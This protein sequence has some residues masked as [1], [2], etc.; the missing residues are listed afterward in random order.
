MSCS[1]SNSAVRVTRRI[2][3]TIAQ[4]VKV[5]RWLGESKQLANLASMKCNILSL[6]AEPHPLVI[7]VDPY[8]RIEHSDPLFN[9]SAAGSQKSK[10][11]RQIWEMHLRVCTGG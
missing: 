5:S 2:R 10:K 3:G 6:K 4:A 9:I 11:S 1:W 7:G 8:W